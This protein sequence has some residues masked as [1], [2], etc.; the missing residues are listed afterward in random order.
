MVSF[1]SVLSAAPLVAVAVSAVD[2]PYNATII[3]GTA[4]DYITRTVTDMTTV[5][6]TETH[7]NGTMGC[8]TSTQSQIA[9]VIRT[10]TEPCPCE[11][12][13]ITPTPLAPTPAP[14]TTPWDVIVTTDAPDTTEVPEVPE[15]DTTST[16]TITG[17]VTQVVS[18]PTPGCEANGTCDIP[19]SL[20]D[21][22][23]GAWALGASTFSFGLVIVAAM[24]V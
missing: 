4:T 15:E 21:Q 10:V 6:V 19:P 2:I 16:L 12:E 8:H 24:L 9:A 20:V 14:L 7:C 23:N 11:K 1:N 13:T 5:C 17:F 18:T 3:A 22:S